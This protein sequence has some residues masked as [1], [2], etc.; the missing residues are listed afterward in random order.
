[1][2][3]VFIS[4]LTWLSLLQALSASAPLI[5]LWDDH[6]FVNNVG[7]QLCMMHCLCPTLLLFYVQEIVHVDGNIA[8]FVSF[9]LC[10]RILLL[11][12]AASAL[13]LVQH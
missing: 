8:N 4:E 1:M 7:M 12:Q 11:F 6:E 5:A 2:P 3:L 10:S 9:K 13:S